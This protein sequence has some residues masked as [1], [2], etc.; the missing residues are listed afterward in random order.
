[1]VA[2]IEGRVSALVDGGY[3]LVVDVG[4]QE[5]LQLTQPVLDPGHKLIHPPQVYTVHRDKSKARKAS[6]GYISHRYTQNIFTQKF[7]KIITVA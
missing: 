6:K 5:S 1:M 7:S 3:T 2:Y 4:L